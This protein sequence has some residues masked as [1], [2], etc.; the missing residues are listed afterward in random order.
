MK[1]ECQEMKMWGTQDDGEE[2]IMFDYSCRVPDG[3][4]KLPKDV[5]AAELVKRAC[6]KDQRYA[7]LDDHPNRIMGLNK[8]REGHYAG[9]SDKH[10]GPQHATAQNGAGPRPILH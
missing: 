1:V 4:R 7:L 9:K 3:L 6:Y 2:W 5:K 8:E 10:D